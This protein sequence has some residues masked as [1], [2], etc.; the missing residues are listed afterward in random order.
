MDAE[1]I[2]ARTGTVE[3]QPLVSICTTIIMDIMKL[4][5]KH[6]TPTL[7]SL[8]L[9]SVSLRMIG[10]PDP[11]NMSRELNKLIPVLSN[12]ETSITE[13]RVKATSITIPVR[14]RRFPTE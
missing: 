5:V 8:W 4:D 9:I 7:L 2:E 13:R 10:I 14:T 1:R 6:L 12:P 11:A 3:A